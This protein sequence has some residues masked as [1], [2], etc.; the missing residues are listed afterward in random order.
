MTAP[1]P[2]DAVAHPN[3]IHALIRKRGEIAGR[4]E[5]LQDE[6]RAAVIDLDAIDAS[7]HIF[8]ATIEL[9]DI[10]TRPVPAPHGAFRGEVTRIVFQTLKNAKMPLTT[11]DVAKR[12]MAERGLDTANARLLKLVSKRV[13]ACL[14][15]WEKRKTVKAEWGPDRLKLWELVRGV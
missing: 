12:V 2:D 4:I 5:H 10:R 7:I 1:K 9:E 11:A 15:H 6:L 3:V 14:R 8:D 13:G